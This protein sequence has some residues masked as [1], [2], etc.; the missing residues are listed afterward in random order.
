MERL[1]DT[2]E[3]AQNRQV[4]DEFHCLMVLRNDIVAAVV[5]SSVSLDIVLVGWSYRKSAMTL[6][7][8]GIA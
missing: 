5:T 1:R 8:S 6:L 4:D 3:E 2:G 7:L